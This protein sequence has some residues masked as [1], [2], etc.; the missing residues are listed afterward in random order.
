MEL[1]IQTS[2]FGKV[3]GCGI[4]ALAAFEGPFGQVQGLLFVCLTARGGGILED[5]YLI[6]DFR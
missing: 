4:A 6:L 2:A 5:S 1:N 3:S